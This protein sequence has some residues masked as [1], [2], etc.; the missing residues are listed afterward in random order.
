MSPFILAVASV[1]VLTGL[2]W[3]AGRAARLAICPAC[4]GIAGTWAWMLAARLAGLAVDSAMLGILMGASVAGFTQWLGDR[5]PPGRSAKLWKA[6]ALP[7]G[8][9]A[10]YGA[11]TQ[12]WLIG[13]GAALLFA[14][15]AVAFRMPVQ[16]AAD[17]A[18]VSQL[19]ERMKR[20]C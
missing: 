10:A 20:C 5:L 16:P 2:A 3:L 9:A 4:V 7:A 6:L 14:G 17:A 13:G 15:L 11:A 8:C 1:L 12:Q 18:A 19:E